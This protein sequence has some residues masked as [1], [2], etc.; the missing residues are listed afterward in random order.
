MIDLN[1]PSIYEKGIQETETEQ[2]R[3]VINTF[4]GVEYLSLRKYYLDFSEEWLPS[5]EGISMPIDFDNSRNL[6]QG[7]VEILSLAESKNILEEEF[8]ELLDQIYLA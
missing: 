3:L 5:K 7:L 6:F 4:R 1:A 2:V 8:K